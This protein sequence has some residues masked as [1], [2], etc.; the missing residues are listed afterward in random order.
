MLNGRD[1]WF[2]WQVGNEVK[3]RLKLV[4]QFDKLVSEEI[5]YLRI[6]FVIVFIFNV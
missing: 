3:S 6:E 1:F 4:D 2:W 5:K